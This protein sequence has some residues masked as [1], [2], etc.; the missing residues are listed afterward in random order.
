M[1]SRTTNP[2]DDCGVARTAYAPA[3]VTKALLR[4]SGPIANQRMSAADML[5]IKQAADLIGADVKTIE[6]RAARGQLI[7]L[8]NDR[9][10]GRL[11]VWQFDQSLLAVL[12]SIAKALQSAD[13]WAL[14]NFLESAQEA[15]GGRTPRQAIEQGD[16]ERVLKIAGHD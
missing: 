11:P 2:V 16:A 14:L 7:L 12:P 15:L 13:G 8:M 3:S 6:G 5:S 4:A 1:G 10:Q 9:R